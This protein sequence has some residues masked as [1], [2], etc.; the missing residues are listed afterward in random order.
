[1][2]IDLHQ[3]GIY[4]V[5]IIRHILSVIAGLFITSMPV[6]LNVK[7]DNFHTIMFVLYGDV[8]TFGDDVVPGDIFSIC[9]PTAL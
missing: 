7:K 8:L 2:L 3:K 4:Q 6:A 1:M 9:L 5:I